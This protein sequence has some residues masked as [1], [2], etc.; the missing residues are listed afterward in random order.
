MTT[1]QRIQLTTRVFVR[2]YR[3]AR[4]WNGRCL[5]LELA[6]YRAWETWA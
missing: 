5:A 4:R 6:L 2:T 1:V 3:L